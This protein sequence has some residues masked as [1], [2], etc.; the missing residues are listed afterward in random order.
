V[1]RKG[2][3]ITVTPFSLQQSHGAALARLDTIA[4]KG[5]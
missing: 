1:L 4:L 3:R 2:N 5:R